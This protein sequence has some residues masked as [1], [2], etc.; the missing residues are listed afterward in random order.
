MIDSVLG[1]VGGGEQATLFRIDVP[2]SRSSPRLSDQAYH[3]VDQS[4]PFSR[5]AGDDSYRRSEARNA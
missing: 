3:V 1:R 4:P 2:P 5:S